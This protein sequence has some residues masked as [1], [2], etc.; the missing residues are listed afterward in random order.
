M[1]YPSTEDRFK[2]ITAQN[3]KVPITVILN[4]GDKDKHW[5]SS[6]NKIADNGWYFIHDDASITV[7]D[8]LASEWSNHVIP[9]TCA[10][11]QIPKEH[12]QMFT[13]GT[14]VRYIRTEGAINKYYGTHKITHIRYLVEKG[15]MCKYELH[16]VYTGMQMEY[17]IENN[18][19]IQRSKSEQHHLSVLKDMTNVLEKQNIKMTILYEPMV[20]MSSHGNESYTPDFVIV[21]EPRYQ[22]RKVHVVVESKSSPDA[23]YEPLVSNKVETVVNHHKLTLVMMYNNPPIFKHIH[24]FCNNWQTKNIE[25][26]QT[27]FSDFLVSLCHG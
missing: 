19:E 25:M 4:W 7:R 15:G 20:L 16:M 21:L 9:K 23:L 5:Y 3:A 6:R 10:I 26:N 17:V 13:I 2:L 11:Y 24:S 12:V 18:S 22:N 14:I 27:I 1:Y 8:R